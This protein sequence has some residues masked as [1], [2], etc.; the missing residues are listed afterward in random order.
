M[1]LQQSFHALSIAILCVTFFASCS[2]DE[3]PVQPAYELAGMEQ[4]TLQRI[5]Q[6]R[7]GAG[8]DALQFQDDI[9][10]VARQHN[11]NMADGSV[12]LGHECFTE[13]VNTIKSIMHVLNAGENVA[14]N[15]GFPDP[16]AIAVDGWLKSEAHKDNIE[17]D[18]N[19]TGIGIARSSGGSYYFT[20]IFVKSN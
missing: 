17:G 6:H 12:K 3:N 20:Q 1:N 19:L 15:S 16:A 18:Y 7:V 11:Q 14:Y 8:K 13:R 9:T 2:K 10:K 5:N 4:Q